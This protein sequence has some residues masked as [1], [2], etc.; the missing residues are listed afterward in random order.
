[1]ILPSSPMRSIAVSMH[2]KLLWGHSVDLLH[3]RSVMSSRNWDYRKTPAHVGVVCP[4]CNAQSWR[5]CCSSCLPRRGPALQ[6]LALHVP[7]VLAWESSVCSLRQPD[8]TLKEWM[9]RMW[10]C[11]APKRCSMPS[12][13]GGS[14][15]GRRLEGSNPARGCSPLLVQCL[16]PSSQHTGCLEAD[17]PAAAACRDL[18]L[19]PRHFPGTP[20]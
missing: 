11:L 16:P 7:S 1:M 6:L 18:K 2:R 19:R 12:R 14:G 3:Q 10:W 17:R 5:H 15:G 13:C 9:E 8:F 4:I 20:C